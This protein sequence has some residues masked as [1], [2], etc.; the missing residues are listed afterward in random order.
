MRMQ[1]I[2]FMLLSLSLTTVIA[3]MV[4]SS[5]AAQASEEKQREEDLF[6][7][8]YTVPVFLEASS[9]QI[10][11]QFR[12]FWEVGVHSMTKSELGEAVNAWVASQRDPN[13]TAMFEAYKR[14]GEQRREIMLS[15]ARNMSDNAREIWER[16]FDFDHLTPIGGLRGDEEFGMM[17][18]E[19]QKQKH[20]PI[21]DQLTR[22]RIVLSALPTRLRNEILSVLEI[23]KTKYF[24]TKRCCC[25]Y[26]YYWWSGGCG[27]G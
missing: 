21:A 14:G 10:R 11:D 1:S 9:P 20:R 15:A 19:E 16:A 6:K 4:T 25:C 8:K 3:E 17:D 13:I 2:V 12:T 23:N 24:R 5:T 26:T 7:L 27:C 18:G 22:A